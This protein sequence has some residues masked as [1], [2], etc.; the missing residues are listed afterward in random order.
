MFMPLMIF[1]RLLSAGMHADRQAERLDQVTVD[2]EAD[3]QP[4]VERLD[5]DVGRAVA[6]RL[7][8][9]AAD[10]LD[11][12]RLIVE[13]HLGGGGG[14]LA[15][16]VAD[17]EGLDQA[18]DVVVGAVGA[19]DEGADRRRVGNGPAHRPARCGLDCRAAC[20]A[21]VGGDDDELAVLLGDG[22]HAVGADDLLVEEVL[23]V[24]RKRDRLRV[25]RGDLG[26]LGDRL[27]QL[28][29]TD[30]EPAEHDVGEL[31]QVAVG[32]RQGDRQVLDGELLAVD[33]QL[34]DAHALGR[35]LA[36]S[37]DHGVG[38]RGG[39]NAGAAV[40]SI[41]FVKSA[42]VPVSRQVGA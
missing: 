30:A 24:L 23:G 7:A 10:Q 18:L 4:L 36:G 19:V 32:G 21:R 40:G 37:R 14:N 6:Q 16:V 29:T 38:G 1:K 22:D 20:R 39:E 3:A 26:D 2:A 31:Q 11:D 13:A 41:F 27:G 28:G 42:I 12:R 35:G 8:D 34:A 25:E 9:D 15:L 5:V 17:L 33:Q